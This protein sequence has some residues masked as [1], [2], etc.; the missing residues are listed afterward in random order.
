MGMQS[1]AYV[2]DLNGF[3]KIKLKYRSFAAYYA[4]N[5]DIWVLGAHGSYVRV[6]CIDANYISQRIYELGLDVLFGEDLTV[7]PP[8]VKYD[9]VVVEIKPSPESPNRNS[10]DLECRGW[11]IQFNLIDRCKYR[12]WRRI[13]HKRKQQQMQL[14]TYRQFLSAMQK[15]VDTKMREAQ[16]QLDDATARMKDIGQKLEGDYIGAGIV[17]EESVA[18]NS[19][20]D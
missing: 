8:M 10:M 17:H 6:L 18:V 11:E 19:I 3:S 15:E 16:T 20:P 4:V 1:G 2:P 13:S 5:P 14:E 9:D 7:S 12:I